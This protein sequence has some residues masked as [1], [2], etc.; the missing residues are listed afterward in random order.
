MLQIYL[1]PFKLFT[2]SGKAVTESQY[3][4]CNRF[5]TN[6]CLVNYNQLTL[7]CF[8]GLTGEREGQAGGYEF[9]SGEGLT[10]L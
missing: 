8:A 2:E 7:S 3:Q 4:E 9:F 10:G 5:Q 1:R 6:Q